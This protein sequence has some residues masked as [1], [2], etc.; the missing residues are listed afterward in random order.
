M[1]D[2]GPR[3]EDQ[4][5]DAEIALKMKGSVASVVSAQLAAAEGE[6]PRRPSLGLSFAVADVRSSRG[7]VGTID[8]T[9][10]ARPTWSMGRS[11][12]LSELSLANV[13]EPSEKTLAGRTLQCPNCGAALEVKLATTQSI[14]CHQCKS[15]IDLTSQQQGNVGG[16]LAHYAQTNG[17]EPLIPLGTVGTIAFGGATAL[18]WQ[19]VGKAS[20][21]SAARLSGARRKAASTC[22]AVSVSPADQ[23]ISRLAPVCVCSRLR[24]FVCA[25]PVPT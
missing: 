7:E 24:R 2:R 13:R 8:Y 14:V 4:Y 15:V 12:A 22:S 3:N 10:P 23:T 18:P 25:A 20:R 5:R 1:W 11:V 17:S 19:V 21:W 6:L 9:D 16:D